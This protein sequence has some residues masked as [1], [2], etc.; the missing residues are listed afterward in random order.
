MT[1]VSSRPYAPGV[2]RM[3]PQPLARSLQHVRNAVLTTPTIGR[4]FGAVLPRF[5]AKHLDRAAAHP[6]VTVEYEGERAEIDTEIAPLI[7]ELWRH[8]I[9][10]VTSCQNVRGRVLVEFADP[11]AALLFLEIVAPYDES[12]E[13]IY[14]RIVIR[15]EP[16]DWQRFRRDR[17]WRLEA[18][19]PVD[20]SDESTAEGTHV[21]RFEMPVCVLFPRA[22]LP[23]VLAAL[24]KEPAR[25]S[26][27]GR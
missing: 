18:G 8:R 23:N 3:L 21:P 14:N 20:M 13:S 15:E 1:A 11:D 24:Q 4:A 25:E 17:V 19:R 7:R 27:E 9:S 22:D 10:T 6:A 16:D 5:L 12:A 26:G 2:P